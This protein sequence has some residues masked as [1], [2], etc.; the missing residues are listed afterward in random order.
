MPT[1]A[2]HLTALREGLAQASVP[3]AARRTVARAEHAA[4]LGAVWVDLPYYAT[5]KSDMARY[6]LGRSLPTSHWG[7]E[8]H[9][10]AVP[11]LRAVIQRGCAVSVRDSGECRLVRSCCLRNRT[12]IAPCDRSCTSPT[13]QLARGTT[14]GLRVANDPRPSPPRGREIPEHL[15]SRG[16]FGRQPMGTSRL[17]TYMHIDGIERL[18][19]VIGELAR[20]AMHDA[21]GNAP[22]PDRRSR[23]GQQLRALRA[24]AGEPSRKA[25]APRMRGKPLRRLFHGEWGAFA[26]CT[27]NVRSKRAPT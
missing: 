12:R 26:R 27:W 10:R 21:F 6:A 16:V 24:P 13:R 22:N 4:R 5:F 7:T 11:L 17:A 23:L 18:D 3:A 19:R 15:F 8:T 9:E 14:Y 25:V 2:I 1:D 20:G